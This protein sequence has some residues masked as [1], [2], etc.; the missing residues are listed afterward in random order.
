MAAVFNS[1]RIIKRF[2]ILQ[3]DPRNLTLPD[4]IIGVEIM[5]D[6]IEKGM[7]TICDLQKLDFPKKL[8]HKNWQFLKKEIVSI[9]CTYGLD[10]IISEQFTLSERLSNGVGC[11]IR[12]NLVNTKYEHL[13]TG[14][15]GKEVWDNMCYWFGTEELDSN[16]KSWIRTRLDGIKLDSVANIENFVNEYT[17]LVNELKEVKG[18]DTQ[19]DLLTKIRKA[20]HTSPTM[21]ANSA[22]ID[23]SIIEVSELTQVLGKIFIDLLGPKIYVQRSKTSTDSKM[24]RVGSAEKGNILSNYLDKKDYAII[25]KSHTEEELERFKE[26]RE[27][28][29]KIR[30]LIS[31]SKDKEGSKVQNKAVTFSGTPTV[32]GKRPAPAK[33]SDHPKK[34]DKTGK[35][36]TG[37]K[38]GNIKA[39]TTLTMKTKRGKER[40]KPLVPYVEQRFSLVRM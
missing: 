14:S 37:S 35:N 15:S 29:P 12:K 19:S 9:L 22:R 10:W 5:S 23:T 2:H 3:G 1:L 8:S 13:A 32:I 40:K 21:Q 26:T 16:K 36:K 38:K 20:T 6:K 25:I 34:K 11:W 17:S 30:Q 33:D 24:R 27:I 4:T 39:G 18:D 7:K 28:T 31:D